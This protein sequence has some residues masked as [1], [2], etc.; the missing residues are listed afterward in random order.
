ML[1]R[2]WSNVTPSIETSSAEPELFDTKF[3]DLISLRIIVI[4]FK[5][6]LYLS[7]LPD[8]VLHADSFN[9]FKE[10]AFLEILLQISAEGMPGGKNNLINLVILAE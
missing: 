9:S 10:V 5:C 8:V 7:F 6:R 2:S 3:F 1:V 4:S